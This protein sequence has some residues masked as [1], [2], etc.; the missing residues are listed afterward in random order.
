MAE[1]RDDRFR[2]ACAL[3]EQCLRE[4]FTPERIP[5]PGSRTA[6]SE[7][8]ARW[9]IGTPPRSITYR[10]FWSMI[11]DA[12]NAGIEPD[13]S[14]YRPK[15]Y[16]QPVPL[17]SL[18]M[19]PPL[20]P[21]LVEPAGEGE[22]VLVIGDLHQ[23]PRHEDRIPI[24]TWIARYASE[25]RISRIIQVGDWST[26]DSV[27]QHDRAD[28]QAARLK[29]PIKADMDNLVQSHQAWRRGM[30]KDYRPKM[31]L[32]LG[33]HE[34]RLERFENSNP[35]AYGSFTTE[36]DQTFTQF[37]WKIRPYGELF[38]VDGVAFT[39]H[40]VNGAGRAYGG[41]TGPQRAANESTI[42]VV[43]GHTHRKQ[44]HDAP[45]IGP[46]DSISMVEVGCA[47]PWGTVESYA[48]HG[49]TGW[50]WGVV[51][52]TIRSG[53]I[54]DIEFKSMLSIRQRYSDDGADTR[55]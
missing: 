41:K 9:K 48:R 38:Y 15:R 18:Q 12:R 7:A 33:N 29:P 53:V 40:P 44:V 13:W 31:N 55:S 11:Q 49:L 54:T 45:K 46:M 2:R 22:R 5:G 20:D 28:T 23:D 35:E 36:R 21:A 25:H 1:A 32:L 42:P 43:S 10:G 24:L 6:L 34:N 47:M 50:W 37:G 26:W 17:S 51:P 30:D 39:H 8:A 3:V 52:M 4:G 16:H 14:A 27:N 19:A